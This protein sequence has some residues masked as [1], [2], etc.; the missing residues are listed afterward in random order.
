M[1]AS[2]KKS[3]STSSSGRKSPSTSR[4]GSS[5][6]ATKARKK[7]L[8]AAKAVRKKAASRTVKNTVRRTAAQR[9]KTTRPRTVLVN[10]TDEDV[11]SLTAT[12]IEE[13]LAEYE[14]ETR[15]ARR[16]I[17]SVPEEVRGI[18]QR[19]AQSMFE[20]KAE[21]VRLIDL[22]GLTSVTDCFVVC[23]GTSDIHVKAIADNIRSRLEESGQRPH[24]VE[25]YAGLSWILL[26]YID[27]VVHV[28]QPRA[29]DFYDLERLWGDATITPLYDESVAASN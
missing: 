18:V 15:V 14:K 12:E 25:G 24:H 7:A 22:R 20:K 21:E 10:G 29:R 27:V 8:G 28:F 1:A 19:I 11:E 5:T 6:R 4:S 26:D 2:N 3:R 23:T 9:K 13:E 16:E 17:P